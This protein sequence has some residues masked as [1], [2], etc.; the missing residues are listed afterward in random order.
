MLDKSDASA[1]AA[2]PGQMASG[3][4]AEYSQQVLPLWSLP[5]PSISMQ[6]D[7][8]TQDALVPAPAVDAIETEVQP[9]AENPVLETAAAEK[10]AP[11][12][13]VNSP[14]CELDNERIHQEAE[15]LHNQVLVQSVGLRQQLDSALT[16]LQTL[17]AQLA[18]SEARREEEVMVA[19]VKAVVQVAFARVL[20]GR[21]ASMTQKDLEETQA[22]LVQ[23]QGRL[24]EQEQQAKTD[25]QEVQRVR[26]ALT[27]AEQGVERLQQEL[28]AA[29]EAAAAAG[30]QCAGLQQQLDEAVQEWAD[31]GAARDVLSLDMAKMRQEL[32]ETRHQY[33]VQQAEIA[34]GQARILSALEGQ[35]VL[36]VRSAGCGQV[37]C[38]AG[39]LKLKD[40]EPRLVPLSPSDTS[41]AHASFPL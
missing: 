25:A 8:D 32:E 21:T 18:E 19:N 13:Q 37:P 22:E 7:N 16:Q 12:W 29:A 27:D 38:P 11:P 4:T 35:A 40:F 23:V 36:Q 2:A 34:A 3:G 31:V 17:N 10:V 15:V 26:V 28:Q 30:R 9:A 1:D 20:A 6:D 39:Q 5:S 41:R 33:A 24:Q 14:S